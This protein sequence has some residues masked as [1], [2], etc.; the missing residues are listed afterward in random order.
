MAG[1]MTFRQV[2]ACL[3]SGRIVGKPTRNKHGDWEFSMEHEFVSHALQ[4]RVVAE[5][6]GAAVVRLIALWENE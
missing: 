4:V 5:C 6:E 1:A 2:L 3:R